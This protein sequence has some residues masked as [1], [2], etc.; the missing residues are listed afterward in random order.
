M[1]DYKD[2]MLEHLRITI[3]RILEEIPSGTANESV[4]NTICSKQY[5]FDNNRARMTETL[6]WLEERALV[7]LDVVTE[8]GLLVA[9]LTSLGER[10]AL[11]VERFPGIEPP[12]R[13]G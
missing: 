11:G 7:K 12:E 6:R 1:P 8:G 10:V 9:A 4:L 5:A 3:L 2:Y 13:R